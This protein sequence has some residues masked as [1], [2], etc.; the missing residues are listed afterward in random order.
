MEKITIDVMIAFLLGVLA[1]GVVFYYF[2]TKLYNYK[3]DLKERALEYYYENKSLKSFKE[4]AD[5]TLNESKKE[6]IKD[7]YETLNILLKPFQKDIDEFNKEIK[8]YYVLESKDRF[9]LKKELESLQ[10][11]NFKLLDESSRLTNALRSDNKFA[12]SWGEFVLEHILDNSG[13]RRGQEY[14][15]Q[16]EFKKDDLKFRPDVIVH[17]PEKRSVVIDSKVSLK[18]YERYVND[19]DK[20]ALKEHITS[21]KNHIKELSKKEYEK[22]FDTIEMV[23]LFIP[24][25]GAFVEA[26]KEEKELFDYAYRKNIVIVSPTTLIT[27]LKTIE[28]SWKK[29]FQNKNAYAITQKAAKLYDK[30][31]LFLD[32]MHS[33]ESYLKKAQESYEKAF[34]KLATGN[35]NLIKQSKE[36]KELENV[37]EDKDK[38]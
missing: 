17:L 28:Y 29:E 38:F 19:S 8:N 15:T 20:E 4:L 14:E 1:S 10:K 34:K 9:A 7:S 21:I 26:I 18:A 35:A 33:V 36:L 37:F 24:I 3:E 32:D 5:I 13:L 23:L 27:V 6:L 12:G 11:I 16:V 31:N 2:Y 30:F 25:E 22:L